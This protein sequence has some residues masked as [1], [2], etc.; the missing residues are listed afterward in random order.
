LACTY[1]YVYEM[2]DQSWKI[3][4]VQIAPS[5]VETTAKR[6]GEYASANALSDVR[7]ILHGGEPLLIGRKALGHIAAQ[8]RLHIKPPTELHLSLQTN[9]I[10]LSS[11]TLDI[12][13]ENAIGVSVSVDGD[14]VDHDRNRRYRNGRG[15]YRAVATGLDLL[16]SAEYRALYR[17]VICTVDLRHEP[18]RTYEALAAFSPPQM[19]FLLPHGN[20]TTPPPGRPKDTSTPYADWLGSMFDH[21]Y[22]S[23][24]RQPGVRI[25]TEIIH[26]LLGGKPSSEVIGVEPTSVVVVETDGT[27][28]QVD[29][30]KSAYSGAAATGMNVW[31]HSFGEVAEHAAFADQVPGIAGLPSVCK[32]CRIATVCG[33][34]YYPHR[35]SEPTGF[36][37]P[38][39]YCADLQAL[40]GHIRSRIVNDLAQVRGDT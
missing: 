2:A 32:Q 22:G 7:V 24:S 26:A 40:I 8:M 18:I 28:E 5:I 23:T 39:V 27:I 9:G 16:R 19:D 34:G 14:E 6:I 21:W 15:S 1:C 13:A 11:R 38:S 3:K 33:G 17:G 37:N 4:P 25:F 30:L 29:A 36:N 31:E 10:L 35:Y 20:W 12:L